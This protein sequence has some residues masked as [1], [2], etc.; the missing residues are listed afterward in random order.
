MNGSAGDVRVFSYSESVLNN[1]FKTCNI[2]FY[3]NVLSIDSVRR[4]VDVLEV[5]VLKKEE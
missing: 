3:L 5:V 2:N 4:R 1:D